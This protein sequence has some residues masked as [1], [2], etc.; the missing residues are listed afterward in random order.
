ML[1]SLTCDLTKRP[2]IHVDDSSQSTL[3][4]VPIAVI[5]RLFLDGQ[6]CNPLSLRLFY[7]LIFSAWNVLDVGCTNRPIAYSSEELRRSISRSPSPPSKTGF[8]EA[9]NILVQCRFEMS[10]PDDPEGPARP[11]SL[12]HWWFIDGDGWLFFEFSELVRSWCERQGTTYA[13]FDLRVVK[14]LGSVAAI[15]LYEI[16]AALTRREHRKVTIHR[17]K[18]R[19]RLGARGSYVAWSDFEKKLM[20]RSI[21]EL[22]EH[23]PF[24]LSHE[25]RRV[26]GHRTVT[27]ETISVA[28]ASAP[29]SNSAPMLRPLQWADL[30]LLPMPDPELWQDYM[31]DH[32]ID[33]EEQDSGA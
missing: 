11:T 22:N 2:F 15:R 21:A 9:L 8:R 31:D 28:P 6:P 14:A 10:S 20:A 5:E 26:A 32:A 16:G 30:D 7:A 19:E 4:P 13:W 29:A 18:L 33:D 1:G 27:W 25:P 24:I 12:L 3:F 23:A 17:E